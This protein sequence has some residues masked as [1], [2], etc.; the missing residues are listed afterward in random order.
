M[1]ANILRLILK[2]MMKTMAVA[3]GGAADIGTVILTGVSFSN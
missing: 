3:A 1:P 2:F